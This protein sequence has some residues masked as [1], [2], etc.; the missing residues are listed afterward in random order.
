MGCLWGGG[1]SRVKR[2]MTQSSGL[3]A[4]SYIGISLRRE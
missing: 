4:K 3:N 1:G 2:E